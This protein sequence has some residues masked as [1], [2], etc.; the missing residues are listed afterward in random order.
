[1]KSVLDYDLFY[2]Q[3]NDHT[4]SQLRSLINRLHIHIIIVSAVFIIYGPF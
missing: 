3:K 1:L 4:F 2:V